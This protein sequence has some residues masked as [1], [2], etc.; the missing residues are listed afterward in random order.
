[1]CAV[2]HDVARKR[3]K[4][5]PAAAAQEAATELGLAED[6]EDIVFAEAQLVALAEVRCSDCTPLS[7]TSTLQHLHNRLDAQFCLCKAKDYLC[8]G[9]W[10]RLPY[11]HAS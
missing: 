2:A 5:S 1:M 4:L 8:N 6:D 3:K 10:P 11:L 9:F 7:L